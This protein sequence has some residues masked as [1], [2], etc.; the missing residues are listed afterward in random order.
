MTAP[1][2]PGAIAGD[3]SVSEPNGSCRLTLGAQ[4]GARGSAQPQGCASA[5]M[6]RVAAWQF[7]GANL[8]LLDGNGAPLIMLRPGA[9]GRYE[10]SG[11][12]RERYAIAR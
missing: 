1:P 9:G 3:W 8:M 7:R 11:L 2:A 12:S 10:G 6:T 5:E 4:P